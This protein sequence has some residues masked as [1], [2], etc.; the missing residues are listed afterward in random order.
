MPAIPCF[1][2]KLSMPHSLYNSL[3]RRTPPNPKG[4]GSSSTECLRGRE[5]AIF[6]EHP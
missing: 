2:Q 4:L 5:P 1:T 3:A 6:V